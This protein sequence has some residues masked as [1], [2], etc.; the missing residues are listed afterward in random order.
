MFSRA[1]EIAPIFV[2]PKIVSTMNKNHSKSTMKNNA[3]CNSPKSIFEAFEILNREGEIECCEKMEDV[4]PKLKMAIEYLNQRM[5]LTPIQSLLLGAILEVSESDPATVS[6]LARNLNCSVLQFKKHQKSLEE[7]IEK[8]LVNRGF[9]RN[10]ERVY[11][12]PKDVTMALEKNEA[13][14]YKEPKLESDQDFFICL[15]SLYCKRGNGEMGVDQLYD[16][17]NNL[18]AKGAHLPVMKKLNEMTT[19][20]SKQE[21]RL[22]LFLITDKR[23][24]ECDESQANQFRFA[25]SNEDYREMVYHKSKDLQLVKKGLVKVEKH[26]K[27]PNMSRFSL[28]EKVDKAFDLHGGKQKEDDGE[29]FNFDSEEKLGQLVPH[30]TIG[31]KKLFY[32]PEEAR[33]ME[34]LTN[35]LQ[36]EN[37]KRVQSQLKDQGLRGAISVLLYGGPGTGKTE[38]VRQLAL[39]TGRDLYV[40]DFSQVRD[41]FVGNTEKNTKKVFDE[42]RS[43]V[44]SS[45]VAPILFINE[46]DAL[47]G[48]RFTN[49][50]QSSMRMENTMQNILL[51]EIETLNGIMVC[52]T[53]LATN[54]DDAFERRFI[55]KIGLEKPTVEVRAK[56]WLSMMPGLSEEDAMMLA[57]NYDLAG[58]NMENVARKR[59]MET[60]LYDKEVTIDRLKELCSQ[61]LIGSEPSKTKRI[62]F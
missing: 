7:M 32:N 49:V 4:E 55:M 53:N 11:L 62:G 54:L 34:M 40:V 15:D 24:F 29:L 17:L 31:A 25:F 52:T 5:G 3:T 6:D 19:F 44:E 50:S 48:K 20:V 16:E 38:G 39:N 13:F 58:G 47:L 36:P 33:N 46:A 41:M 60:V 28:T 43:L 51:Q 61:E 26:G 23:Q 37:Y 45:D 2:N 8:H 57:E 9:N 22:L 30:S 35:L 12:I 1:F 42:Y 56:I 10:N 27:H 21:K 18:M 59:T 14:C